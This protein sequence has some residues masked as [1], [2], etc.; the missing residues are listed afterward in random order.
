MSEYPCIYVSDGKE[1]QIP[2]PPFIGQQEI[3]TLTNEFIVHD[4]DVFV[5][6]YP[7]SGT[8]WTEQIA[9]LILNQGEQGDQ[10]L[11]DAAP[12]LETLPKRAPSMAEFLATLTERRL[13]TCH[14]PLGLMPDFNNHKGRYIYVARNPKDV[15]VSYYYHDQS[16]QGYKGTWD[17]HV[18]LFIEGKVMYGSYFDHVLPW[19]QAS[20]Q[21]DNI[22]FLKYEDMKQDLANAI[23]QIATF[24]DVPLNQEILDRVIAGSS[25]KAMTSNKKTNFDW[26]P[27]QEGVPKHFRKG[28]VGD[29]RT[30]FS[31]EQSERLDA[32]YAQR[33][34]GSNLQFDFGDGLVM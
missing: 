9:H 17:E 28:I 3:D 5:V 24:I 21:A 31:P 20:Q 6:T 26:V 22:L 12:W 23:R 19:W 32:L 29:W 10:R 25:F 4:D 27:Q 16:K 7:R 15:A 11:T 1:G 30:Q 2:F 13:F 18:N 34:A 14:L 8:T 33:M